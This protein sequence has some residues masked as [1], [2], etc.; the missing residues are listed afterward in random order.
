MV[1]MNAKFDPAPFDKYAMS[2]DER[3]EADLKPSVLD[4]AIMETFPASD[5]VS[6]A[7]PAPG[8]EADKGTLGTGEAICPNCQGS[9]RIQEQLCENCNGTGKVVQGVG[10]G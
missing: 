2:D 6:L 1:Q 8:D 3:L 10:G 4:E 7:Q 5:P 9:G